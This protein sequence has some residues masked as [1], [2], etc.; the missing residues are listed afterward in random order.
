MKKTTQF[1]A[2]ASLLAM[3]VV[4]SLT[5]EALACSNSWGQVVPCGDPPAGGGNHQA[6]PGP[7]LAGGLPFLGLAGGAY[8]LV[9][10]FRRKGK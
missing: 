1:V 7:L 8:W 6:A 5:M 4:P 3:L 9:R 2:L 10:R